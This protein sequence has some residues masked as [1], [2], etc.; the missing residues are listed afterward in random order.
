MRKLYLILV[1]C[2]FLMPHVTSS[3]CPARTTT[4]RW[5]AVG[6]SNTWNWTTDFYTAY[7]KNRP[8]TTIPS[9]FYNPN[10]TFQNPNLIFLQ[11]PA[12]KDLDPDDG[13]ELLVKDMGNNSNLPATAVTN[14]FF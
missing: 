8:Y 7:I 4:T 1:I 11:S 12:T 9:P 3:Q 5:D 10:S 2:V 6:T 13:W 14:P